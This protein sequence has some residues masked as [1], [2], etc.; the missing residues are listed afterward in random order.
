MIKVN[1]EQGYI[2]LLAEIL[3]GDIVLYHTL[4]FSPVSWGIRRLICSFWNHASLYIGN[5]FVVEAGGR[6]VVKTLL[7]DAIKSKKY[8]FKVVRLREDAFKDKNKYENAVLAAVFWIT[9]KIGSKYDFPAVAWLALTYTLLGFLRK[10][11][12]NAFHNRC[13]FFC[14]E[15]V[16]ES[17]SGT[18]TLILHLFAGSKHPEA[19]CSTITPKDLGKSVS[20]QHIAGKDVK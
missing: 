18:S 8:I 19:T 14:S 16:C 9:G 6:G 5:G 4:G 11:K 20:V 15:L 7:E 1:V 10:V 3:P 17:Y 12:I 2:I 13:A